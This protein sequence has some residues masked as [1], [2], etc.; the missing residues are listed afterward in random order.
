MGHYSVTGFAL[1]T[2]R[3][4]V[5]TVAY[6]ASWAFERW[7]CSAPS[8]EVQGGVF[9]RLLSVVRPVRGI[10][11]LLAQQ[12]RCKEPGGLLLQ[13]LGLVSVQLLYNKATSVGTIISPLQGDACLIFPVYKG[14]G[15]M[16]GLELSDTKPL[17]FHCHAL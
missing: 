10:K 4:H 14:N 11:L 16:Q 5:L 13:F 8:L 12:K 2:K 1:T 15:R 17:I 9:F 7:S 3:L 6:R